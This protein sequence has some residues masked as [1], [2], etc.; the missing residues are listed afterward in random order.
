[1]RL[2]DYFIDK[3]EVSNQEYKE[4]VNAGGYANRAFWKHAFVKDGREIPWETGIRLLVDRT[5][6]PGPRT[7]SNQS[8]L[9][10]RADY[11]VTDI[12]WYEACRVRRFSR[13]SAADDLSVGK[14]SA[15]RQSPRRRR[16]RH[17]LGRVLPRRSARESRE[18]RKGY[19]SDLQR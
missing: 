5:G 13:E 12:T 19:A 15:Q 6:L 3:Y 14:G 17:A 11:P 10:G 2:D 1:M 8:F 7:W 18:L 16:D 9:D 4:F